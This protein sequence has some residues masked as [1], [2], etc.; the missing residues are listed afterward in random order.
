MT[1]QIEQRLARYAQVT[2]D[3]M[4]EYLRSAAPAQYLHELV[5]D[6]PSRPG[7]GIRP[8]LL[9]AACQAYGGSLRDGLRPAISLELLHNAFL[10][11]DDVEDASPTRRGAPALHEAHGVA[12]A[13]NTGDA[14]AALALQPLLE[15]DSLGSRVTRRLVAEFLTM[16][17]QTTEGQALELG[18]RRDNV[19]DLAPSDYLEMAVKKTCWYT[20]VSPLRMGALVGSRGAAA[21]APLSRFGLYAGVA[22]QLRDDTLKA[23]GDVREG[24]RTLMLIHL[25]SS[26]RGDARDWLVDYL[27]SPQAERTRADA[28]AV[29][30]LMEAHGSL[31]YAREYARRMAAAAQEQ[32]ERAF[33]GAV[34]S[35]AAQLIEELVPYMVTRAV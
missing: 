18:W 8:A 11:H 19:V 25:L 34:D 29:I 9:L 20:T 12:L 32:F 17:R 31:G 35:A 5:A 24:K 14:L 1:G 3:A 27:A 23:P 28:E 7:K 6:Y 33:A 21:L 22:F 10:V 30:E 13:V 16:V 15:A 4:Q 26:V 2:R